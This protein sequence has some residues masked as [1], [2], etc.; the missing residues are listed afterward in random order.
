MFVR[1]CDV[2][3]NQSPL[4]FSPTVHLHHETTQCFLKQSRDFCTCWCVNAPCSQSITRPHF[5]T[6]LSIPSVRLNHPAT[7]H[8]LG[9][10]KQHH[11]FTRI[12]YGTFPL[13]MLCCGGHSGISIEVPTRT[14]LLGCEYVDYNEASK[15]DYSLPLSVH[16]P[17]NKSHATVSKSTGWSHDGG[18]L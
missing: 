17:A 7:G 8:D 11:L 12:V 6:Q 10:T 16:T 18:V 2:F 1:S 13:V 9:N 4:C 5:S 15:T 14:F 3:D